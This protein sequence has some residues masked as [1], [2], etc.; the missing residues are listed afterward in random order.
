MKVAVV[1]P[2]FFPYIGYIQ[3]MHQVDIFV[4]FDD[5]NFV[6]KGWIKRNRL[7]CNGHVS[8]FGLSIEKASQNKKINELYIKRDERENTKLL[9]LIEQ[10]YK[11]A[12][13]FSKTIEL[14]N[15]VLDYEDNNLATFLGHQLEL[16]KDKLVLNTKLIYSSTLNRHEQF[17]TAQERIIAITK[18]LGGTE[19]VN[20]PGGKE[21][22]SQKVFNENGLKLSFIE[23][24][25]KPY[26]QLN[27]TQFFPALSII[28][29][30]M[31]TEP[32]LML[33]H[34]K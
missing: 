5:V 14:I 28:D 25:L 11:N 1:Q 20:L 21:L 22:Y 31:N 34:A 32:K 27:T 33:S 6:K 3:L 16:L 10:N 29:V 7:L 18:H 2:Y 23:P 4:I 17:A 13:N 12:P 19:Y 30:M 9:R 24:N 15:H 26:P 8:Y